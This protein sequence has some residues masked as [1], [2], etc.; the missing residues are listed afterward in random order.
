MDGIRAFGFR[1]GA[2]ETVFED[3][4]RLRAVPAD[5]EADPVEVAVCVLVE[6]E[7]VRAGASAD[8]FWSDGM[9]QGTFA[10]R[11]GEAVEAE[12]R[13]YRAYRSGK[14][15]EDAWQERFRLYWKVMIRCRAILGLVT[16]G[17]LPAV[18]D[19][20]DLGLDAAV[21]GPDPEA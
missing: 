14:I 15:S 6:G 21:R 17:S 10:K 3:G 19:P 13:V 8:G 2:A 18:A 7:R 4:T 9:D 16:A 11:L 20:S 1:D 12:R 5:A